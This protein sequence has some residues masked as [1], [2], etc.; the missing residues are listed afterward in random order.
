MLVVLPLNSECPNILYSIQRGG[1]ALGALC[2][3]WDDTC[4]VPR[5]RRQMRSVDLLHPHPAGAPCRGPQP[6]TAPPRARPRQRQACAGPWRRRRPSPS[7][8]AA[9]GTDA[10]QRGGAS[11]RRASVPATTAARCRSTTAPLLCSPSPPPWP[12]Q[13]TSSPPLSA[14]LPSQ[15]PNPRFPLP[16]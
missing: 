5:E 11:S 12:R 13:E 7:T 1:G 8:S 3:S 14:L 16:P 10:E 15:S 4:P 2:S 6:S 9:D